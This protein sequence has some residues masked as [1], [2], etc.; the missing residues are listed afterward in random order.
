MFSIILFSLLSLTTGQRT[1][2]DGAHS[3]QSS[4]TSVAMTWELERLDRAEAIGQSY[5]GLTGPERISLSEWSLRINLSSLAALQGSLLPDE[6]S[7]TSLRSG[8]SFGDQVR[9]PSLGPAMTSGLTSKPMM[10]SP[11]TSSLPPMIITTNIY[12]RPSLSTVGLAS[13][14]SGRRTFVVDEDV[15]T[16]DPSNSPG[17]VI[18]GG[19]GGELGGGSTGGGSSGG[20]GGLGGGI[21]VT[22]EPSSTFTL[23]AL[24]G[25]MALRRSR[26]SRFL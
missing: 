3:W 17:G 21:I 8:K 25:G 18:G 19:V 2:A 10:T 13:L 9:K 12:T 5:G 23:L 4:R 16:G 15:T 14:A 6:I 11:M 1:Y 7:P 26:K 24:S 22:P 20:G